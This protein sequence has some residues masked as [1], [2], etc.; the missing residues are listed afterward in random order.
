M[1]RAQSSLISQTETLIFP[2]TTGGARKMCEEMNVPFLGAIPLDPVIAKS[3]DEG[4]SYISQAPESVGA[5]KYKEVF[6]GM[7]ML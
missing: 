3:C 5:K 7:D 2:P 4:K 1:Q 6:E